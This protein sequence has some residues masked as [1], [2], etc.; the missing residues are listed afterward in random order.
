M[1]DPQ[2]EKVLRRYGI[3]EPP[4]PL[5]ARIGAPALGRGPSHVWGAIAA[6]S[7]AAIWVAAHAVVSDSVPDP[8]RE[9]EV[10]VITA[11]LGGGEDMRRYAEEVVPRREST[12]A[13][14]LSVDMS[15]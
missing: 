3:V 2:L 13:S 12:L 1:N 7:I 5:A 8:V 9:R 11:T 15:W 10:T 4:L 14:E 6:A